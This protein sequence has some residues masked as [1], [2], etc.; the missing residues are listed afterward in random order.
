MGNVATVSARA[1][2]GVRASRRSFVQCGI[3]P[4]DSAPRRRSPVLGWRRTIR[5]FWV[6]ATSEDGAAFGNGPTVLKI[7]AIISGGSAEA[8]RPHMERR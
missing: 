3:K 6:G 7:R 4:Q 8:K 1:L 5:A 2:I